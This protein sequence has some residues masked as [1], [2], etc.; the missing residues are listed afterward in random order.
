MDE[1]FFEGVGIVYGDTAPL[2]WE[3]SA[4]PAPY[5]SYICRVTG[6]TWV[7]VGKSLA[8]ISADI[9]ADAEREA[10]RRG[11]VIYGEPL[12]IGLYNSRSNWEAIFG[13]TDK[14]SHFVDDYYPE[15]RVRPE[16]IVAEASISNQSSSSSPLW[17]KITS[18]FK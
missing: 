8:A 17:K 4:C 12:C 3:I 6:I 15:Q 1:D 14:T 18:L 9:K 13:P 10:Q 2:R 7:N 5:G 11:M 16:D